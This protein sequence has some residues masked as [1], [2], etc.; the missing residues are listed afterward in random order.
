MLTLR[1]SNERS[2]IQNANQNTWMTFDPENSNDPLKNGFGALKKINEDILS[3]KMEL[4]PFPTKS[5]MLVLTYVRKGAILY[6]SPGGKTSSLSQN[7]FQLAKIGPEIKHDGINASSSDEAQVF[8]FRFDLKGRAVK[9]MEIKKFFSLAERKGLLRL[10]AS[11]DG[12]EA[13]LTIKQDFQMYSGLIFGGTHIIHQLGPGR[14]AW[15]H[16]VNGKIQMNG[17]T[18][19][20]GDGVGFTEED[21]VAFTAKEPSSV[22]LFDLS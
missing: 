1:T 19:Q 14:R 4:R 16:V 7:E 20:T 15:L 3:P 17:L 13:S 11:S 18:L 10:I 8:Q 6:E 2:H 12:K 9:P 21:S 22:I 5:N